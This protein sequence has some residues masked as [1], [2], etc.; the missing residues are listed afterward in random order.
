MCNPTNIASR[1][2]IERLGGKLVNIV[3]VPLNSEL[4]E[5]GDRESCRYRL[6]L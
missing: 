6:D 2:T 3:R 4:Y 1:R 5:L